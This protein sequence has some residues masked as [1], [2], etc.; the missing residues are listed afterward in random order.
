MSQDKLT[1]IKA[2]LE[3]AAARGAMSPL[4]VEPLWQHL[5]AEQ[6]ART[7]S[8]SNTAGDSRFGMADLAWYG[9]GTLVTI[10]LGFF[11]AQAA[12]LYGSGSIFG[13]ALLYIAGFSFLGARLDNQGVKTPAGI[14]YTVAVLLVPLAVASG[15]DSF[16][17]FGFGHEQG[18]SL[19]L[20]GVTFAAA[21]F[22]VLKSRSAVVTAPLYGALWFFTITLAWMLT[23]NGDGFLGYFSNFNHYNVVSMLTGLGLLACAVGVDSRLGRKPDYSWWGYFF[24]TLAFWVPLSLM[25]SGGEFGKLIYFA[26]NIVLMVSSVVLNRRVLLWAGAVGAIYYVG[27]LLSSLV[28]DSLSLAAVLVALGVGI[29]YLG[30]QYRRRQAAIEAA[31]LAIVPKS[32]RDRL[33]GRG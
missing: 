10:A 11:M 4:D 16:H 9:G 28:V 24:G 2:D 27:H 15:L 13:L 29:I 21:L 22:A 31:I 18:E 25:D 6:T 23:G 19:L 20:E 12:A 8:T 33:P 1:I 26:I 32:L 7:N 30:V 3:A 14:L 5:S 17:L